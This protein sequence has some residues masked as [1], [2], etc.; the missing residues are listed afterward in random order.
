[1]LDPANGQTL[2]AVCHGKKTARASKNR[3]E[4]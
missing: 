2:C 1:M 3:L 4:I